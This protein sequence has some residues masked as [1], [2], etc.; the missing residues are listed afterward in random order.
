MNAAN[1]VYAQSTRSGGLQVRPHVRGLTYWT[2]YTPRVFM[3]RAVPRRRIRADRYKTSSFLLLN[4][5]HST[6][7]LSNLL[8][9]HI[10]TRVRVNSKSFN[11]SRDII[12]AIRILTIDNVPEHQQYNQ[13]EARFI[14]MSIFH[15]PYSVPRTLS[16]S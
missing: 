15:Q 12:C 9:S 3:L 10:L 5:T 4:I 2:V 16:R 13:T 7:R 6:G 1:S 8:P 14:H 11:L